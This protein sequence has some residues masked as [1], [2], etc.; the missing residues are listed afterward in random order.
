M[1]TQPF[2]PA[3]SNALAGGTIAIALF[4]TMIANNMLTKDTGLEV[5]RTAQERL[6]PFIANPNVVLAAQTIGALYQRLLESEG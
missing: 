1:T 3:A 5:L 6:Q 4:E 2:D